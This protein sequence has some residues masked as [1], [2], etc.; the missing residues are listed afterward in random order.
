MSP[1]LYSQLWWS[2]NRG[3]PIRMSFLS[4]KYHVMRLSTYHASFDA[5]GSFRAFG[6]LSN[7]EATLNSAFYTSRYTITHKILVTQDISS[8]TNIIIHA[9]QEF[10]NPL[11]SVLPSN[12]TAVPPRFATCPRGPGRFSS[13][14]ICIGFS[15][16]SSIVGNQNIDDLVDGT[17]YRLPAFLLS[18]R[19]SSHTPQRTVS[20]A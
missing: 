4:E 12:P 6:T 2:I 16:R 13:R 18:R 9:H 1:S 8:R 17:P 10:R 14:S 7:V 11:G 3:T 19:F 15:T 5:V 20:T